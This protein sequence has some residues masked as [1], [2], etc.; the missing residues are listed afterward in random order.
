MP[1]KQI[2]NC[3]LALSA[4]TGF[5]ATL[6]LTAKAAT[7]AKLT[8]WLVLWGDG[9]EMQGSGPPPLT[10]AHAYPKAIDYTAQAWV[11]DSKGGS[12]TD[13]RIIPI[14]NIVPSSTVPPVIVTPTGTISGARATVQAAIDAA[15]STAASTITIANGSYTWTSGVTLNGKPIT[16]L[17]ESEGGVTLVDNLSAG[18][19]FLEVTESTFGHIRIGKLKFDSRLVN[20]GGGNDAIMHIR[21]NGVTG[22]KA[23]LAHNN[24][25]LLGDGWNY[26]G[27]DGYHIHVNRGVLYNNTFTATFTAA[28]NYLNGI[29]AF[30][31]KLHE[32]PAGLAQWESP[33]TLGMLDTTGENNLYVEDCTFTGLTQGTDFDDA[34][35][36]VF[37]NNTCMDTLVLSHGFDSS[38]YGSRQV[39]IYNNVIDY[40]ANTIEHPSL[41][42]VP[43][44]VSSMIGMRGG[45]VWRVWGNSIADPSTPGSLWGSRNAM[46]MEL[47][48]LRGNPYCELGAYPLYHQHGRGHDGSTYI[49]DPIRIW[50]NTKLDTPWVIGVAGTPSDA[51]SV[52]NSDSC[53]GDGKTTADFVQLNRDY[54]LSA[55]PGYVPYTYPHPLRAGL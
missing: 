51:P 10:L 25:H 21:F 8:R 47:Y 19:A 12:G 28:G 17:G 9:T 40:G 53:R 35:R 41:G 44:N 4:V 38:P 29:S 27:V 33:S 42:P 43:M 24:I 49:L 23:I 50:A 22:G 55:G 46:L 1:A 7:R 52:H 37:R 45:G 30:R 20:N 6:S 11:W 39:E 31:L 34:C 15:S 13:T 2:T 32:G 36:V 18:Q 14:A 54:Y 5:T 3:R 26:L 16:I 48:T